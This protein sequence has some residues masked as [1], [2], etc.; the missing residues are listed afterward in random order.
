MTQNATHRHHGRTLARDEL[1][2]RRRRFP[3]LYASQNAA[4]KNRQ[5]GEEGLELT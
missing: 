1:S 5:A 2:E 3:E 4:S